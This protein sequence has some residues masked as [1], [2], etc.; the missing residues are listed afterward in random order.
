VGLY[1]YN[2]LYAIQPWVSGF[3]P[4]VI[5]NG[6]RWMTTRMDTSRSK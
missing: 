3:T 1:F 6:Q 5:Y 4:P 2:E